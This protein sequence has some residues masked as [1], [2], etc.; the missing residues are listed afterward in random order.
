MLKTQRRRGEARG[1]PALRDDGHGSDSDAVEPAPQYASVEGP[2]DERPGL[3]GAE[4][5][6]FLK[7]LS[8]LS[9]AELAAFGSMS[10][11]GSSRDL[12]GGGDDKKKRA[13]ARASTNFRGKS[14]QEAMDEANRENATCQQCDESQV[15]FPTNLEGYF[16]VLDPYSSNRLVWDFSMLVLIMVITIVTP[17]ELTFLEGAP[18]GK[19]FS[20][21]DATGI[22]FVFWL[23]RCSDACFLWDMVLAFQTS[24]DGD[25]GEWEARKRVATH[26]LKT[27]FLLDLLSLIPYGLLTDLNL[28]QAGFLRIIRLVRLMKLLRLVKQPRIMA[29]LK[30]YFTIPMKL[31]T[32]LKYFILLFVIIHWT[33]CVLRLITSFALG[34]CHPAD[35][36]GTR[37]PRTYLSTS[38]RWEAGRVWPQ[39]A[40]AV[41]WALGALSGEAYGDANSEETVLNVV[42]LLLGIVVMAFLVG[43]LANILGNF[44]PVGNAFSTTVDGLNSFL[45]ENNFPNI[46]RLKLREYIILSEPIYREKYYMELMEAMS[47]GLKQA[48]AQHRLSDTVR[49]INFFSYAMRRGC[50]IVVHATYD[51]GETETHV[52]YERVVG[53]VSSPTVNGEIQQLRTANF[54]FI[55]TRFIT[56][57]AMKLDSQLFMPL[58]SIIDPHWSRIDSLYIIHGQVAQ[59][60]A[61]AGDF[62]EIIRGRKPLLKHVHVFGAWQIVRILVY[63]AGV[64]ARRKGLTLRQFFL[65]FADLDDDAPPDDAADGGGGAPPA[66]AVPVYNRAWIERKLRDLDRLKAIGAIDDQKRAAQGRAR[67]RLADDPND[68]EFTS[69]LW[70]QAQSVAEAS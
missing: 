39:Y 47:P 52:P 60:T 3:E 25:R 6:S 36:D 43:E 44:D 28:G 54:L 34:D 40:S 22:L 38:R 63:A 50:G 32:L 24:F 2:K 7:K 66:A 10:P 18:W 55:K 30:K 58:E 49:R 13:R 69:F 21:D 45:I 65:S 15:S 1:D 67:P 23:N 27:W 5:P 14:M 37:C 12:G 41:L 46:L 17:F 62:L 31:Q 61:S 35:D 51:G 11:G 48:V 56:S 19:G 26:Y 20:G 16:P 68:P 8:V 4:R 29:K 59:R 64:T 42:V 53:S 57:F 9:D 33:A 70:N